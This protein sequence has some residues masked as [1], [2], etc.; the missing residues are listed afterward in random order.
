MTPEEKPQK[1]QLTEWKMTILWW[2]C[3]PYSLAFPLLARI[4]GLEK[5]GHSYS[6]IDYLYL[7]LAWISSILWILAVVFNIT[8]SGK[9]R[10]SPKVIIMLTTGVI[11]SILWPATG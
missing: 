5:Y 3:V 7:F 6:Q 4:T 11:A 8:I 9:L 1:P 2:W 10:L